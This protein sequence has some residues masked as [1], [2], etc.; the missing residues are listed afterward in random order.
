MTTKPSLLRTLSRAFR[1]GLQNGSDQADRA[2]APVI[3]AMASK[4]SASAGNAPEGV[5][6]SHEE[7]PP[8]E[9]KARR[10]ERAK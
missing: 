7:R 9:V 4:L 1:L 10:I 6:P 8:I 2:L 5:S 3:G